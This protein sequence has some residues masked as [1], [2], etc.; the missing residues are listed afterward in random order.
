MAPDRIQPVVSF[1]ANHLDEDLSLRTLANQAG[2]SPFHL[3]RVFSSATGETA[4]QFSMRL[5]LGRAALMLLQTRQPVIDIA[6]E[7][8]FQSHEVFCRA[9]RK[10]LGLSPSKYRARGFQ[11]GATPEQLQAHANVVRQAGPCIGLF[12]RGISKVKED[13]MNYTIKIR[14]LTPQPVL[15]TRRRMK[16]DAIA[17]NLGPMFGDVFLFGQ[18]AGVALGGPPLARYMEFG[19]GMVT[20][21]AGVPIATEFA[22]DDPSG[23]V[24]GEALPGGMVATTMHIGPYDKLTEAHAAMEVWIDE[25]GLRSRGPLWESYVTDPADYP[26][27]ND[28]KTEIFWPVESAKS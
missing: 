25:Q 22:G 8:G 17:Q 1:V 12:R 21:D 16:R 15:V 14:E 6:L 13:G 9:F 24:R 27:P 5:R 3:H 4:K 11:H 23:K 7:C 20:I 18:Q 2:L 19:P 26:D 28:W 10:R